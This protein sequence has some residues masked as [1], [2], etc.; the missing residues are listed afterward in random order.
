MRILGIDPGTEMSGCVILDTKTQRIVVK[1]ILHNDTLKYCFLSNQ[2]WDFVGIE[3][4]Q[5]Y[6]AVGKDIRN[7]L[8]EIGRLFETIV[9]LKDECIVQLIERTEIKMHFCGRTSKVTD[10]T[11]RLAL[12]DRFGVKGTKKNPGFLYGLKSHEWSALAIV[13]YI[14]DTQLK[15]KRNDRL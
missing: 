13:V 9:C 15:G 10:A 7:T 4:V 14:A 11:I 8:I 1:S 5:L 6:Q 12:I 3:N 2:Q